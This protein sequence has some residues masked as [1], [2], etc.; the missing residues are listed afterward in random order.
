MGLEG[1]AQQSPFP[2]GGRGQSRSV[3][4]GGGMKRRRGGRKGGRESTVKWT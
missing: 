2:T 3:G 1:E 4:P